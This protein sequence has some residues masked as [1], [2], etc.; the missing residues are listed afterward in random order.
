[1]A[2]AIGTKPR[3]LLQLIL[4]EGFLIA[5]ISCAF[6]IA[7]GG[8]LGLYYEIN[9][10]PLGEFE[11]AGVALSNA[12]P[13]VLSINQFTHFPIYVILLTLTATLYP[14]RFAAKIVP[15]EALQKSL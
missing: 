12:I 13:T 4:L 1:M 7:V 15:S 2:K 6:G 5:L 3:Q 11:F 8:S 9:G 10:I 14:A